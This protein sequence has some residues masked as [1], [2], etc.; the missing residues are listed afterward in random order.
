MDIFTRRNFFIISFLL[1]TCVWV[2]YLRV[3]ACPMSVQCLQWPKE[4][5]GSPGTAETQR[6]AAMCILGSKP[7]FSAKN[8][9]TSSPSHKIQL[10]WPATAVQRRTVWPRL[11]LQTGAL[12]NLCH[13]FILPDWDSPSERRNQAEVMPPWLAFIKCYSLRNTA[14]VQRWTVEWP[15]FCLPSHTVGILRVS[16]ISK[17]QAR[18]QSGCIWVQILPSPFNVILNSL[19]SLFPFSLFGVQSR[20]SH[21]LT[22]QAANHWATPLLWPVCKSGTNLF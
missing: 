5:V 6:G 9:Q 1:F 7:G 13:F 17:Q 18:T 3:C 15:Y 19:E 14:P 22:R 21:T 10:W 11:F 20:V 16:E 12:S 4:G 2:F 8:S